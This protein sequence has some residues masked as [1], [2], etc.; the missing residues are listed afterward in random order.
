M[1]QRLV[2]KVTANGYVTKLLSDIN[3]DKATGTESIPVRYLRRQPTAGAILTTIHKA[4]LHQATV[5]VE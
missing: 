3:A 1:E 4:T 5:P 2:L